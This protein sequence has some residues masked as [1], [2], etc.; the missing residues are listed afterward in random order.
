MRDLFSSIA[1][2]AFYRGPAARLRKYTAVQMPLV[3]RCLTS[4][5][6]E[7]RNSAFA[8]K[9]PELHHAFTRVARLYRLS[10]HYCRAVMSRSFRDHVFAAISLLRPE[11]IS[12]F[13]CV[14]V[15]C[16]IFGNAPILEGR[17]HPQ[18]R[19]AGVS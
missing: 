15:A 12:V 11:H 8:C 16:E 18:P 19:L 6:S 13:P 1:N 14:L 7:G 5:N 2:D 3:I 17:A 10:R 9:I 4:H